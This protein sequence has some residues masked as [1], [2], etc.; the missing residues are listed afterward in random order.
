METLGPAIDG[1]NAIVRVD[2]VLP[3]LKADR[4]LAGEVFRNL[5]ANAL[6]FNDSKRPTS[7]G[8]LR[9]AGRQSLCA[10]T[11]SAFRRATTKASLPCSADCTA[12]G[13]MREPGQG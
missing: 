12:G 8:G 1:R 7:R 6:K 2:G 5:I 9:S 10:T 3:V 13:N 4:V 11:A